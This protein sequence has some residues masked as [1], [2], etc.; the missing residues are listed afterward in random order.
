MICCDCM[1]GFKIVCLNAPFDWLGHCGYKMLE[2]DACFVGKTI[3]NWEFVIPDREPGTKHTMGDLDVEYIPD[4]PNNLV[5]AHIL[6]FL[7][8]TCDPLFRVVSN[9]VSLVCDL[10]GLNGQWRWLISSTP[11]FTSFGVAKTL[12]EMF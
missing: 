12:L 3:S 7:M 9:D 5:V 10:R 4:L 11:N 2:I 1:D 6:F 8:L